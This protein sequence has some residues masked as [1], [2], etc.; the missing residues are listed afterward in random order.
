[1]CGKIMT[2]IPK[3]THIAQILEKKMSSND[4]KII[5]YIQQNNQAFLSE[6]AEALSI[7]KS[8][9]SRRASNLQKEGLNLY[10]TVFSGSL[11]RLNPILMTALTAA[12]ALIP[13][14]VAGQKP[15][16]EIQSPMAIVILGGLLSS[17]LLNIYVVPVTYYLLNRKKNENEF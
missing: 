11:D 4:R 7:S 9:V 10:D 3:V 5:D 2:S 12:L 16:N 13:L 1:M 15:G 6:I 8:T 14:V 17:T